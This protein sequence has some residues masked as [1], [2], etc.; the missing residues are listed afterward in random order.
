[1]LL[2]LLLFPGSARAFSGTGTGTGSDPFIIAD[3]DDLQSIKTDAD[4]YQTANKTYKLAGD[5]DCTM[6]NPADGSF[7]NGGVWGDSTGFNPIPDF[8]GIFDGD[9]HTIDGLFIDKPLGGY[10]AGLF[11]ETSSDSIVARTKLTNVDITGQYQVG[12]LA[13]RANGNIVGVSVSGSV[14]GVSEGVGGLIGSKGYDRSSVS[15]SSFTGTVTSAGSTVGGLIG[16]GGNIGI[17]SDVFANADVTGQDNVG[18]LIGY[19]DYCCNTL[20]NAY[21]VGSVNGGNFVGG[22]V[23]LFNSA[24]GDDDIGNLFAASEVTA[25]GAKGAVFGRIGFTDPIS[26]VNAAFD[27]TI[28][29]IPDCYGS[30]VATSVSCTARNTDGLSP[31]YFFENANQPLASWN[32]DTTWSEQVGGYPT[33]NDVGPLVGPGSVTNLEV[34]EGSEKSAIEVSWLAPSTTGSFPL[35][36][37]RW[38]MKESTNDWD[39]LFNSDSWGESTFDLN[40]LKLGTTY[41]IR[42]QATTTYARGSWVEGSYTTPDPDVYEASTCEELQAFDEQGEHNDTYLLASDI[43][44]SGVENFDPLGWDNDFAGIFDGQGY[45]ISNVAISMVDTGHIGLFNNTYGAIIR[46]VTLNDAVIFGTEDSYYCGVVAGYMNQTSIYNVVINNASVTC[47][48]TVGGVAGRFGIENRGTSE[49]ENVS[50][51]GDIHAVGQEVDYGWGPY[52]EGGYNA[53]GLFGRVDA[54]DEGSIIISQSS[55]DAIV[56]ADAQRAGGITGDANAAMEDDTDRPTTL[57]IQ[58]SYS[59]GS[60][61]AGERAGGIIGEMEAYNDGYEAIA[62]IEIENSYSSAI[63]TADDSAGGIVGFMDDPS[64]EGEQYVLNNVFAA[65][66]VNAGAH[67]YALIGSDDGLGDGSLVI[68]NSYFDQSAT[69]QA[70]ATAYDDT[71]GGWTAVNTDGFEGDYFK[72]N[73]TNPPLDQWD[74]NTVWLEQIDGFPILGDVQ[75]LNGDSIPDSEQPQVGGYMSMFTSKI[76][77]IDVGAGCE[78]TTDDMTMESNLAVQDLAYEYENG[79]WDFEADCGTPGYTTTIRLFYYD[80]APENFVLRKHNP[81]TNSF[82]TL[83]DADI[84]TRNIDGSPVTVVTYQVTDGG[85]RDTDGEVNGLI[86]DPAGLARLVLGAPNT[87]LGGK[88]K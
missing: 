53:G 5:I 44:C 29:T 74:F 21:A 83:G 59:S 68:N 30:S 52:F 7:D 72:N 71:V 1:M 56:V 32:F 75:D 85:E 76:V 48:E 16:S 35:D 28:A 86:R 79:L 2:G 23:G 27:Q 81:L 38:E 88:H 13:G 40:G 73:S 47:K 87:G 20:T 37:Y 67:D 61:T 19:V 11:G 25:T 4:N 8:E 39:V 9:N 36:N 31:N 84:T 69:G 49:A 54:Q 10:R 65:G 22:L 41:D 6:T 82:F 24:S 63:V 78:L 62:E 51:S 42:V 55:S 45:T 34:Q 50:V 80:V 17:V 14:S 57:L 33:I 15:K 26:V 58:D 43:D 18:G 66:E 3:C 77:A 46:D 12:G 60:V 70:E 64:D